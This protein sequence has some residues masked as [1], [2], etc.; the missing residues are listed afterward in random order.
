MGLMVGNKD[1]LLEV[2]PAGVVGERRIEG[3]GE[4]FGCYD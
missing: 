1:Q 2:A 4:R 3:A